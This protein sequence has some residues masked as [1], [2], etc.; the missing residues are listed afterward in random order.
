M[1]ISSVILM[2]DLILNNFNNSSLCLL[3]QY[4]FYGMTLH[5]IFG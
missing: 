1:Q 4:N 2:V 5:I 3:E